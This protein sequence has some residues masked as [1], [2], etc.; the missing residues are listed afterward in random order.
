MIV[1]VYHAM[2]IHQGYIAGNGDGI[3]TVAGKPASRPIHLYESMSGFGSMQ[4]VA[5]QAS[6]QNGHYMFTGLNPKKR[7]MIIV[8]DHKREYEP[9]VFDF[10]EPAT[11]LTYQEQIALRDSWQTN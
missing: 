10:V 1:P 6:L 11:D 4:L 7:Y 9:F 5:R 8:R 3:V 2:P